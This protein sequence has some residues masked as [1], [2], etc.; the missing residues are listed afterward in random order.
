MSNKLLTVG[1]STYDDF[2]GVYFTVQALRMYHNII[3]NNDCEII[4][5]DNNPDGYHSQAL[6]DLISGWLYAN[7]RLVSSRFGFPLQC[8]KASARVNQRQPAPM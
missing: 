1:M 8:F 3:N 6:K 4:I 7:A 5:I 2:D